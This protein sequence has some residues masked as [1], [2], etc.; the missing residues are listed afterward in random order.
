MNSWLTECP[1]HAVQLIGRKILNVYILVHSLAC[2]HG[3]ILK[4]KWILK[5]SIVTGTID[6]SWMNPAFEGFEYIKGT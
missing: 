6:I 3:H 5:N 1:T 4:R 2:I